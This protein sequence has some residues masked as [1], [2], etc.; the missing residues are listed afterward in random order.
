MKAPVV[1]GNPIVLASSKF[2]ITEMKLIRYMLI[3][4]NEDGTAHVSFEAI[5]RNWINVT[6]LEVLDALYGLAKKPMKLR[7]NGISCSWISSYT[8]DSRNTLTIAFTKELLPFLKFEVRQNF[9]VYD[10]L[11]MIDIKSAASLSIYEFCKSLEA[12]QFGKFNVDQLKEMLG[13]GD[14]YSLYADFKRKILVRAV[15]EVSEKTDISIEFEEIKEG[16]KVVAIKFLVKPKKS[17]Q[18]T[19]DD[20]SRAVIDTAKQKKVTT[21]V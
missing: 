14:A 3:R 6:R 13:V 18:L 5:S 20:V 9:I 16:R 17:R 19:L 10:F 2:T 7:D 1:I 4:I 12:H 21:S 11:N 8:I 15:D